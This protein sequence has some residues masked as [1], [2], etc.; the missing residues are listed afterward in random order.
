MNKR[1]MAGG[2][3]IAASP[4]FTGCT[5]RNNT[6]T[7]FGGG[8]FIYLGSLPTFTNCFITANASGTSTSD[9]VGGG[10]GVFEQREAGHPRSIAGRGGRTRLGQ[11]PHQKATQQDQ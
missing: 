7:H 9:G 3:I 1:A 6:A 8:V 4:T 5:I 10:V 2:A 11:A